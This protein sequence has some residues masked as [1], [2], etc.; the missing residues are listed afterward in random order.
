MLADYR[1]QC[2]D[3]NPDTLIM[4]ERQLDGVAIT[5]EGVVS[6]FNVT[7]S[8]FVAAF[9][10]HCAVIALNATKSVKGCAFSC[11]FPLSSKGRHVT[12]CFDAVGGVKSLK[13]Y[14]LL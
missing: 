4:N 9:L 5:S 8:S 3:A 10:D 12:V 7:D 14:S 11:T 6:H 2:E 1:S 13:T